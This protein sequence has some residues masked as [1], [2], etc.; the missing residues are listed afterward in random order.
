MGWVVDR[1]KGFVDI[2]GPGALRAERYGGHGLFSFSAQSLTVRLGWFGAVGTIVRLFC[3]IALF[4]LPF[5]VFFV[6][7]PSHC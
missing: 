5:T 7:D 3:G 6:V 4:S 1:V 2:Y